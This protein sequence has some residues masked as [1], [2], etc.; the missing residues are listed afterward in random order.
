MKLF[1]NMAVGALEQERINLRNALTR[2][3]VGGSPGA[4]AQAS[5]LVEQIDDIEAI[6]DR[7]RSNNDANAALHLAA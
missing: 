4:M 2:L 3:M 1:A 7:F 6:Q 5:Q